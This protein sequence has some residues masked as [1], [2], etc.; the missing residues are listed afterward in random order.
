[1]G[2]KGPLVKEDAKEQCLGSGSTARAAQRARKCYRKLEYGDS[3][4]ATLRT[5]LRTQGLGIYE[6]PST[7][8]S[9]HVRPVRRAAAAGYV[10]VFSEF[11]SKAVPRVKRYI[12][13]R[14][15]WRNLAECNISITCRQDTRC[16]PANIY[17]HRQSQKETQ[18]HIF[19]I[20]RPRV[21]T[22]W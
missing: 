3:D 1:M 7:Q 22:S 21:E 9:R 16:C 18:P 12:I 19:N 5:F 10:E 15:I 14:K 17:G 8:W 4:S 20:S 2:A 13:L 11:R 6:H